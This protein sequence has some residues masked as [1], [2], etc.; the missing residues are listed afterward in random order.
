V[1]RLPSESTIDELFDRASKRQTA[2]TGRPPTLAE[3]VLAV[4]RSN[5]DADELLGPPTIAVRSAA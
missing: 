3:Q 4:D 1:N 2:V 5:P